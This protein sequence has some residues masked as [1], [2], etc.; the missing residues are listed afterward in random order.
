MWQPR[1]SLVAQ[2][3]RLH[4]SS[5]RGTGSIPGQRTKIP[6]AVW[7]KKIHSK[8][9]ILPVN[10]TARIQ[11]MV[12]FSSRS[13]SIIVFYTIFQ[14]QNLTGYSPWGSQRVGQTE[15]LTLLLL[16]LFSTKV[17]NHFLESKPHCLMLIYKDLVERGSRGRRRQRNRGE[18]RDQQGGG[19]IIM[20]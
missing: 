20:S 5:A 7:P 2:W 10:T 18:G 15:W 17:K 9:R 14:G 8:E 3:L 19:S 11:T 6:H 12:C 1:T 13:I 16:I 4:A